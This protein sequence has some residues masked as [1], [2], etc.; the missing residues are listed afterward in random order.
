MLTALVALEYLDADEVIVVGQEIRG[1]PAGF[2]TNVPAEGEELTVRTLLK[3]MLIRGSNETGRILALNT[4]R[5]RDGRINIPFDQ[6]NQSFAAM[7]NEEARSLGAVGTNFTNSFGHQ[8]ENHFTTAYD[9]ALITRAFMANEVLAEIA[10]LQT[11][12]NWTNTNQMLP[13]GNH[14]YAYMTG[15]KAGFTL[16]AGHLLAGAAEHNG[17]Q[18]VTVVLGGTDAMRWQD[19]RRL[20]DY[21]FSNFAFREVAHYG[22][23]LAQVEIENPRLG[24]EAKL[25][26]VLG[27]LPNGETFTALLRHDRY[28]SISKEIIF[29]TETT[30]LRAPLNE[31]EIVGRVIFSAGGEEL[32]TAPVLASR[33]IY[34]RN[35]DSD[36]DYHL[37]AFFG[38]VF[39]RQAIPYYFG[40][41]GMAFGIFGIIIAVRASR[42]AGRSMGWTY[43]S[44]RA[45]KYKKY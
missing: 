20:M 31:G 1:M 22:E 41:F 42:R 8:N 28:A 44:G 35:F 14:G 11:Y 3:A 10:G 25:D 16:S 32:F 29:D 36:M 19:T 39:S 43:P 38:N 37:A 7:L 15:A 40:V 33:T 24:D 17:L 9:L 27:E 13:H 23:I 18:L 5:R 34:E 2:A 4:V 45:S 12:E 26:V 6:A 30:T 21:G